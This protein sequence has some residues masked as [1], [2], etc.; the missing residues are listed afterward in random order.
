MT[1]LT[2]GTLPSGGT[3]GEIAAAAVH[4]C[5]TN[6]IRHAKGDLLH[7]RAE[8]KNGRTVL[9]LTNSGLKPC[10]PIAEKGGLGSLR[11]LAERAGGT[12]EIAY[13][14]EFRLTVI[15]PG[16][17]EDDGLERTGRG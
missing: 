4:E 17:V 8:K 9:T 2:E 12:M 15:L 1:V 3:A 7:V 13:T 16:E 10:G 5:L 6:T 14:P 11:R